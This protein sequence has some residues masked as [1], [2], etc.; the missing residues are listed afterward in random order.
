MLPGAKW[1]GRL[2]TLAVLGC[3]AAVGASTSIS[4]SQGWTA[5][6]DDQFLLDVRIRQ[7]RLGEGMRAYA[8][9][10]GTCIIFGDFLSTLDVPMKMDLSAKKAGGWAFKEQNRIAIDLAALVAT[11]RGKSEPI[12][13][14]TV[15]ETPQGWCV[16]SAAL[17]RWF[18]IGVKPMTAGST[19]FLES[20]AKLPVELA[21]ERQLRAAQLKSAKFDTATLPQVRLPYRMWRAPALD[22]V[23]SGG[24]TY[25]AHDG[26]KVDRQSSVYAAGEIA[27]LSYDAQ[28]S[29]TQKGIP[30]SLRLRAY[31]S[32]PDGGLL[33]PLKATHFGFGD[34]AGLDS[35]LTG[36]SV[37]GR[38]AV[39]TNR[40]LFAQSAFDRTRFEGDL[41][42]GWDAEIYRNGEL[43]A[44]A[45][46][47]ADQRYHFED[48]QLLYGE[49]RMTIVLYGPQGQI[50]NREE[51]INVGQDNVPAGKTWYWAGA[52]QPGRDLIAFEHPP[53]EAERPKAQAAISIEHGIDQRTT[54]GALARVM[55]I[56]DQRLTFVEGTVRRSIGQAMVEVGLAGESL[57]GKAARAQI[58]A[59]FGSVNVS[60]E[61]IAA[62]DF[63][64]RGNRPSSMRDYRLALDAPIRLG[65]T[66]F[67]AHAD[68]HFTGR[69]DGSKQLEAAARLSA[70]L[71]R[72]N[73]ATDLRYRKQY[74]RSGPSP[75][76]ELNLALIGSGRV[77]G[78]RLRGSSSFDIA[79]TA[80]FRSAELSAY[81]SA[82]DTVDW[83]GGLVYDAATHRGRAR[84]THVRRLNSMAVALTG[85]AAS[86]GSLALGFNLNFSLD[87]G[88]GF[89]LS[90]Q[91]LA[92]AGAVNARVYRDLND[93]GV[94]DP[95]EP[96]E[97]GALV[98]TGR[99]LSERATDA[100]GAVLVGGLATFTPVTVGID[101]SSLADPMLV[102]RKALQVVVPRPGVAANVEIGLVGG[103]D[104]EGAIVKSGGLGFEGLGLELVDADGKTVASTQ[105]DFDGFFLFERVPYGDYR[106]R[107]S[108]DSAGATG[109]PR[110]LNVTVSVS[111]A[112][113]IVRLG[114]IHVEPPSRVASRE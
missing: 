82:S 48:V 34:V 57:G 104:V 77:G 7:L 40:P 39:V 86:D 65:R 46:P 4:P 91:P 30:N 35:R 106:I 56:D 26:V 66:V 71:D 2:A 101:E 24:V 61:A 111:A 27:H 8:T 38:G 85:E 51:L 50:R 10:E 93:N 73:L 102:P 15:R 14:G 29:T 5:D 69:L 18:G 76:G 52:N 75:P 55:L 53:D 19:V 47:T 78:V 22:F 3:T 11:F 89:K 80:R 95:S 96:Y 62:N 23:V 41:P 67:P 92:A 68:V 21:I 32:D 16:D 79:P 42:S 58:L 74:L 49:N 108:S 94:H 25:R 88:G 114:A 99:R 87:P 81:W 83:E 100:S 70:N 109:L 13:A 98:T 44:F 84:I 9:P 64:L 36:S 72:F 54:V 31:R 37:S 110:D 20:E 17:A 60:A 90:R 113:S 63:H 105:S 107:L 6:P 12:A 45:K 103:G 33:G 112:K 97:K 43:L 59:K 1:L 28:F